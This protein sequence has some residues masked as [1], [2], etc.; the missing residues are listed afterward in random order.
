MQLCIYSVI[1]GKYTDKLYD[2]QKKSS[3]LSTWESLSQF[4]FNVLLMRKSPTLKLL[5]VQG[6]FLSI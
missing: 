1:I 4:R 2:I 3:A 6:T 5:E